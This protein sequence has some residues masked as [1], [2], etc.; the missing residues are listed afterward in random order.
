MEGPKKL[1]TED[2]TVK[3]DEETMSDEEMHAELKELIEL[4]E[5]KAGAL[6]KIIS[7]LHVEVKKNSTSKS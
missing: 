4:N 5:I 1:N 6:K 2:E 7:K 3:Q